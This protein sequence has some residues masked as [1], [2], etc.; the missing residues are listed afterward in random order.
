[1]NLDLY[2][3]A[4][5]C[6]CLWIIQW[7]LKRVLYG[8]IF[9]NQFPHTE[10]LVKYFTAHMIG[11][12]TFQQFVNGGH[13]SLVW[14]QVTQGPVAVRSALPGPQERTLA[15][16]SFWWHFFNED[17]AP[18]MTSERSWATGQRTQETT[19]LCSLR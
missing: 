17:M 14:L 7:K 10:L 4:T 5:S 15:P 1:M 8:D 2:F 13:T 19:G 18:Q 3:I 16:P 6:F 12:R 9:H 11:Q